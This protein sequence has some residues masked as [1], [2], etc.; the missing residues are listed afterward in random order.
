MWSVFTSFSSSVLLNPDFN[1]SKS[2]LSISVDKVTIGTYNFVAII[3][4]SNLVGRLFAGAIS[5]EAPFLDLVKIISISQ[6]ISGIFKVLQK[7]L[8]CFSGIATSVSFLPIFLHHKQHYKDQNY[9][10]FL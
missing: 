8:K 10:Y 1:C 9:K 3:W 7:L 4:N 5:A 6:L 2:Y